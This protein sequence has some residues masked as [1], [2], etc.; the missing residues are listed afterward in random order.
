TNTCL[1]HGIPSPERLLPERLRPREFAIHDHPVVAAPCGIYEDINGRRLRIDVGK[2]LFD[3]RILAVIAS[4]QRDPWRCDRVSH[5]T[6][7]G[8]DVRALFRQNSGD[9]TTNP[10]GTAANKRNLILEPHTPS[11][12]VSREII[13]RK[14]G[15]Q[16]PDVPRS[17]ARGNRCR[18]GVAGGLFSSL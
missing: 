8:N 12:S 17:K 4:N 1:E 14:N 3:L 13:Y 9:A 2:Q 16:C 18:R 15:S 7:G 5:C 10:L 11:L 6:A